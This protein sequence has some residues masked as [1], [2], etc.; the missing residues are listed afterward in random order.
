MLTCHTIL[1][2]RVTVYHMSMIYLD[3]PHQHPRNAYS[4]D[5][6][7]PHDYNLLD[8]TPLQC[9]QLDPARSASPLL[10]QC[11]Q[12]HMHLQS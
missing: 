8:E 5:Y 4:H 3:K 9:M 1:K 2:T 12:R 7:V 11:E 10:L 6:G